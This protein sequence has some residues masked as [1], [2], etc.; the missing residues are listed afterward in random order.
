MTKLALA[1][2]ALLLI[3]T[4]T[5]ARPLTPYTGPT[6]PLAL[7]DLSGKLHN[8]RDYRGKVV[9][10]QFWATYCPP[11]IEEMPS[12]QRLKAKLADKP[13]AI[14]AVNLGEPEQR[15]R[16]FIRKIHVN[17]TVLLDTHGQALRRWRV[18]AVPSTFII[19]RHGKIRYRF[20]GAQ[21]GD[22]PPMTKIISRLLT[23]S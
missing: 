13:F 5:A 3:A 18:Y 6:P 20:Y 4:T 17:F 11:C 12:V 10:V 16:A 9:I 22:K 2:L 15:V 21:V 1:F 19:D 8:L 23:E 7:R 14:L